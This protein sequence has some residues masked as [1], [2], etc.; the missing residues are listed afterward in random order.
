[1]DFYVILMFRWITGTAIRKKVYCFNQ[2]GKGINTISKPA[3]K[4]PN[5]KNGK[6]Q[7][8]KVDVLYQYIKTN[9]KSLC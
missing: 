3:G 1:M 5:L 4:T 6:L 7:T 8:F 9:L 2:R